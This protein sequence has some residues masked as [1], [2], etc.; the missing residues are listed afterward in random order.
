[1]KK[2]KTILLDQD[3]VLASFATAAVEW[4]NLYKQDNVTMERV[5]KECNWDLE[6][7]WSLTQKEWWEIIDLYPDFWLEIPMFPWA[8]KLHERL[9]EYAEEIVILTAPSKSFHCIPH[10]LIWLEEKM[11]IDR[12]NV[13]TGKKKYLLA[14]PDTLLIDDAEHN[15]REFRE[16]GG[17]AIQIPS[18]WNCLDLTFDKVWDKIEPEI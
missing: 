8:L 12:K 15:C 13:I 16:A 6:K 18:D 5:V 9:C 14:R 2:Y 7:M 10:K 3:G 1:M 11:G 4:V 17:K